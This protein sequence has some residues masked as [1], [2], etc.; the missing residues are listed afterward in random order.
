MNSSW[1]PLWPNEVTRGKAFAERVAR[2]IHYEAHGVWLLKWKNSGVNDKTIAIKV[3]ET[4]YTAQTNQTGCFSLNLDLKPKDT[5]PTLY[6]ITAS[7]E[8]TVTT[9]TNATAWTYMIDGTRY[10]TCTTM[11]YNGY[12]P[13]ANNVTLAAQ[14][15]ATEA[16]THFKI[17]LVAKSMYKGVDRRRERSSQLVM[18]RF[19]IFYGFLVASWTA[20]FISFLTAVILAFCA[21][22]SLVTRSKASSGHHL[23]H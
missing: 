16:V 1:R 14:H 13:S 5:E 2:F 8:D 4:V 17:H 12:K 10:A 21:S 9:V 22:V 7:F 11:Q 20:S 18:L 6:T 23:M 3:N 19:G 15:Q